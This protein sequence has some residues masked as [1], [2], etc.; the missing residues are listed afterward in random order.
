[1]TFHMNEPTDLE[2]MIR[3]ILRIPDDRCYLVKGV[4][5]LG[6]GDTE[7]IIHENL[8]VME[9]GDILEI[10]ADCWEQDG[11]TGCIQIINVSTGKIVDTEY[12]T[13][14]GRFTFPEVGI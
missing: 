5:D 2:P 9:A 13:F 6:E 3:Q 1:M 7:T 4:I 11:V 12:L 10:M 8:T 14:I